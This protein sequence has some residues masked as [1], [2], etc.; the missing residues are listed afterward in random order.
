MRYYIVHE[1]DLEFR[2]ICTLEQKK[3]QNLSGK[4]NCSSRR[5]E[6]GGLGRR[7]SLQSPPASKESRGGTKI[8]SVDERAGNCSSR[9][10]ADP[11]V[12]VVPW[13]A[14]ASSLGRFFFFH[15]LF[16]SEIP[17]SSFFSPFRLFFAVSLSRSRLRSPPDCRRQLSPVPLTLLRRARLKHRQH[18]VVLLEHGSSSENFSAN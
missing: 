2:R 17:L 9:K 5:A 13:H 18:C 6:G 3:R 10:K 8:I 14:L 12:L 16:P 7:Q 11:C 15:V 4:V 1:P